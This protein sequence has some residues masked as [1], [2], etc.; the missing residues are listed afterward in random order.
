MLP[1]TKMAAGGCHSGEFP[2]LADYLIS[3]IG[4]RDKLGWVTSSCLCKKAEGAVFPL[5]VEAMEDGVDDAFDA[6][7]VDEADHGSCSAAYFNETA[8]D[9]VS[10]AQLAPQ[11]LGKSEEG[12]HL[13]QIALQLPHYGGI[14]RSPAAAESPRGSLCLTAA[15]GQINGLG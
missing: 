1:K 3:R 5:L 12:E 9:D 13:G 2:Y 10:G 11:V 8:F 6:E 15:F 14:V 4:A 7:F